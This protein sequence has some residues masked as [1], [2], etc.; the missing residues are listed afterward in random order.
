[1]PTYKDLFATILYNM[2]VKKDKRGQKIRKFVAVVAGTVIVAGSLSVAKR[3]IDPG[4]LVTEVIDGDTF[5]ISNKQTIRLFVNDAP[6]LKYCYGVESKEALEKKI[7]G[8][9]VILK[10]PRIDFYKRV[11][12]YV[13]LD[14]EFINE[15]MSKNGY[16]ADHGFGSSE[17][18]IIIAAGNFAKENKIGIFS[19][20]CSPTKPTKKGCDIKG[21]ISYHDGSKKYLLP[22]CRDYIQTVVEKFRGEDYFCSE[23]EAKDAGFKKSPNCSN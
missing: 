8:K 21:Q 11:Q 13:Y 23:K 2:P 7:L 15:Y 10:N 9:K 5:V 14:G 16:S 22:N 1:M 3:V 12:A 18:D 17:S 6:E 19:E 4:E 20:K